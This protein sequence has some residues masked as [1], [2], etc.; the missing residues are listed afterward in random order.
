M[1][2]AILILAITSAQ[3][4][5]IDY[6]V[7][8]DVKYCHS[9]ASHINDYYKDEISGGKTVAVCLDINKDN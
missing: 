9:V 1:Y 2:N 3:T 7:Y 8:E 6:E 5:S 4:V